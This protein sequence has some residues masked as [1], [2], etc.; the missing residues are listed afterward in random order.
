MYEIERIL[1]ERR[2]ARHGY[3]IIRN[4]K[5]SEDK[6]TAADYRGYHI[7]HT[8]DKEDYKVYAPGDTKPSVSC[9]TYTSATRWIDSQLDGE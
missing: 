3:P 1:R 2:H 9:E 7:T 5:E 8:S 6:L 4:L